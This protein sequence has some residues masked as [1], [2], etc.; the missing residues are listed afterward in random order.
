MKKTLIGLLFPLL[1]VSTPLMGAEIPE[2]EKETYR[3]RIN[4]NLSFEAVHEKMLASE[5]SELRKLAGKSTNF[6]KWAGGEV[7]FWTDIVTLGQYDDLFTSGFEQLNDTSVTPITKGKL[8][9]VLLYLGLV[10]DLLKANDSA[11]VIKAFNSFSGNYAWATASNW[12]SGIFGGAA[13]LPASLT[14][15][16][17]GEAKKQ[18]DSGL[19]G[20][21]WK[22]YDVYY[23]DLLLKGSSTE[24]LRLLRED[25]LEAFLEECWDDYVFY[26]ADGKIG[27]QRA[28]KDESTK[29]YKSKFRDKFIREHKKDI[30]KILLAGL[31]DELRRQLPALRGSLAGQLE[32][33]R[34]KL[35]KDLAFQLRLVDPDSRNSI[36]SSLRIRCESNLSKRISI[37]KNEDNTLTVKGISVL[38]VY[39]DD[40]LRLIITGTTYRRQVIPV[41]V[42]WNMA[43]QEKRSSKNSQYLGTFDMTPLQS[44][45]I[46]VSVTSSLED[47]SRVNYRYTL[48]AK[49]TML[50]DG[51][52][53]GIF[54]IRSVVGPQRLTFSA[55]GHDPISIMLDFKSGDSMQEQVSLQAFVDSPEQVEDLAQLPSILPSPNLAAEITEL[56]SLSQ[57]IAAVSGVEGYDPEKAFRLC[58]AFANVT[59]PHESN[60]IYLQA[61]KWASKQD[62]SSNAWQKLTD[63]LAV[64]RTQYVQLLEK[65]NAQV[66]FLETED[67]N[68]RQWRDDLIQKSRNG[69]KQLSSGTPGNWPVL[70]D[71]Y[72]GNDSSFDALTPLSYGL[73]DQLEAEFQTRT[74]TLGNQ[75]IHEL[76]SFSQRSNYFESM[77]N[78]DRG[79]LE[80]AQERSRLALDVQN[81]L[82]KDMEEAY[83]SFRPY[84]S[85]WKACYFRIRDNL[86]KDWSFVSRIRK[87]TRLFEVHNLD[88][89]DAEY[90]YEQL[91]DM[92]ID[93]P[94]FA[95]YWKWESAERRKMDALLKE[96][97]RRFDDWKNQARSL[98]AQRQQEEARLLGEITGLQNSAKSLAEKMDQVWEQ[99]RTALNAGLNTAIYSQRDIDEIFQGKRLDNMQRAL[100]SFRQARTNISGAA[101]TLNQLRQHIMEYKRLMFEIDH[102]KS[103]PLF[104]AIQGKVPYYRGDDMS[105]PKSRLSSESNS[106]IDLQTTL[107]TPKAVSGDGKAGV[108]DELTKKTDGLQAGDTRNQEQLDTAHSE[109]QKVIE[110]SETLRGWAEGNTGEF[111]EKAFLALDLAIQIRGRPLSRKTQLI[112]NK[113]DGLKYSIESLQTDRLKWA[114]KQYYK[115]FAKAYSGGDIDDV[116]AFIHDDWTLNK[117]PGK[118]LLRSSLGEFFEGFDITSF[119]ISR[120]EFPDFIPGQSRTIVT[121]YCT[122]SA[123]PKAGGERYSFGGSLMESLIHEKG[124]VGIIATDKKGWAQLNTAGG[125]K[126]SFTNLFLN[127]VGL[128]E[129]WVLHKEFFSEDTDLTVSGI[130][131]CAPTLQIQTVETSLDWGTTF[132]ASTLSVS[133]LRTSFT[134][135]FNRGKR[136]NIGLVI[137]AT[138]VDGRQFTYPENGAV[139]AG[140]NSLNFDHLMGSTESLFSAYKAGDVERLQMSLSEGFYG[141]KGNLIAAVKRDWEQYEVTAFS[142]E[143]LTESATENRIRIGLD[144]KCSLIRRQSGEI[145]ERSGKTVVV[146]NATGQVSDIYGGVP[147]GFTDEENSR[148]HEFRPSH[149]C[150]RGHFAL[151]GNEYMRGRNIQEGVE[152]RNGQVRL[153]PMPDKGQVDVS[154]M[155]PR[156][157]FGH[158]YGII[159]LKDI[160]DIES[161]MDPPEGEYVH[162]IWRVEEGTVMAAGCKDKRWAVLRASKKSEDADGYTTIEFD[163]IYHDQQVE[164]PYE[165]E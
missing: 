47:S 133:G 134:H 120:I 142:T 10:N 88:N 61:R 63:W 6:L 153:I 43:L 64:Y 130:I 112:A 144:W 34:G 27:V 16:F 51:R 162:A 35:N 114:I 157:L 29:A 67:R 110:E 57:E 96:Y 52:S 100:D 44:A 148:R 159:E 49:H 40:T 59:F 60:R 8:D 1:L 156:I 71:F 74:E 38:D 62:P 25:A 45:R 149:N 109:M 154:L 50:Q 87:S 127:G 101:D 99:Y 137:R 32:K 123:S 146:Y 121:Y 152:L 95:D 17:L 30:D 89:T 124:A 165:E 90:F 78:N 155:A 84:L 93:L 37:K 4:S 7:S 86:E 115:D 58:Q 91:E 85:F 125:K 39:T 104:P 135:Q 107:A 54:E 82:A 136:S 20:A 97:K 161:L 94:V 106:L 24:L 28:M 126:V 31:Q 19:E 150:L 77:I 76:E 14:R 22:K 163:F 13:A 56:E 65:Y 81:E 122:L 42:E 113:V 18:F 33:L 164:I 128:E 2:P 5:P 66:R 131:D 69:R 75:R 83:A 129:I 70:I 36:V 21:L 108:L 80:N 139:K 141:G 118:E 48:N 138:S 151:K 3:Q 140:F 92:R 72:Y 119:D 15:W 55:S 160:V 73:R 102:R 12:V 111:R 116:M 132:E 9:S 103:D 145:L 79:R 23:S 11:G 98:L 46:R 117:E 143:N 53:S 158:L 26:G 41:K 68:Y 105:R 147:F